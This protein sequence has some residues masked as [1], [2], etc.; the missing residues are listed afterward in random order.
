MFSF[1]SVG[2]CEIRILK[3]DLNFFNTPDGW[4]VISNFG[5]GE[6]L[7]SDLIFLLRILLSFRNSLI[8]ETNKSSAT[9]TPSNNNYYYSKHSGKLCSPNAL[10]HIP[11]P[12]SPN[13]KQPSNPVKLTQSS[14]LKPPH[15]KFKY[16]IPLDMSIATFKH[17]QTRSFLLA[18]PTI[19]P[20]AQI[21]NSS[22]HVQ[23]NLQTPSNSLA[24]PRR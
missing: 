3:A 17:Y 22:R 9:K 10:S 14:L 23:S 2:S 4:F 16:S 11:F 12:T 18:A 15:S 24:P 13:P 1:L 8:G 19:P 5:F 6:G 7:M 21:L 20:Q